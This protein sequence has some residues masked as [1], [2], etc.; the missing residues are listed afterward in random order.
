MRSVTSLVLLV[1]MMVPI[2]T[3]PTMM[4]GKQKPQRHNRRRQHLGRDWVAQFKVAAAGVS[5]SIVPGDA[6]PGHAAIEGF[7]GGSRRPH[8]RDPVLPA[9]AGVEVEFGGHWRLTAGRPPAATSNKPPA[10]DTDMNCISAS[11][12]REEAPASTRISADAV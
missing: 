9:G 11:L 7:D 2:A 5:H 4:P 6:A 12:R 8:I 3:T 1:P 10:S